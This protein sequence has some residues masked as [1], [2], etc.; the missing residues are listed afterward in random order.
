MAERVNRLL[1]KSLPE[2]QS[3]HL[4]SLSL[5]LANLQL[6]ILTSP[7]SQHL[8]VAIVGSVFHVSLHPSNLLYPQSLT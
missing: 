7:Q 8:V 5:S 3:I 4:L 2:C 6:E 1:W